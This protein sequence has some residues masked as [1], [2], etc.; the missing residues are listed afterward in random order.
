M[1]LSEVIT[2]WTDY[3][4]MA[5]RLGYDLNDEIIYRTNKLKLRHDQLVEIIE[6]EDMMLQAGEIL[7]DF[8]HV[9]EHMRSVKATYEYGDEHYT[10]LVPDRIEDVLNEG[11]N[12]HHCVDKQDRYWDRLERKESYV[13]FL[14]RTNNIEQS[15][16]TLEVEPG[17][18]IRQKRTMYDRQEDDI[19]EATEFLQKWQKE[20]RKR[21]TKEDYALAEK[22]RILRLENFKQLRK[23]NVIINTG[24]LQGA[25]LVDVLM[26]DLMVA[27]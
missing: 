10:V 13:F 12:L 19:E 27:A 17:G 2:T 11:R 4:S 16:Y 26:A 9:E 14:R 5:A 6:Q 25:K 7:R 23:D 3:L 21:L 8:P 22:S 18:T 1:R 15:Y 20:I 24:H